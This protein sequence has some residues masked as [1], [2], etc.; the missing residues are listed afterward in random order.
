MPPPTPT[1]YHD[2][3]FPNVKLISIRREQGRRTE[4]TILEYSQDLTETPFTGNIPK[5][6]WGLKEPELLV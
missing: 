5:L 1:S 3:A 2:F 6:P 4:V